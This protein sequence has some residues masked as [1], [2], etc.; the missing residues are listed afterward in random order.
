MLLQ[1][2]EFGDISDLCTAGDDGENVN[3]NRMKDEWNHRNFISLFQ[4]NSKGSPLFTGILAH[5]D[6][7]LS[8]ERF[9]LVQDDAQLDQKQLDVA[10]CC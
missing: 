5:L 3:T 6:T 1:E 4:T 7:N 9:P 10:A 2:A 8:S